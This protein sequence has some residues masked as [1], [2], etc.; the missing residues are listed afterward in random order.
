M[1]QGGR[2]QGQKE[3]GRSTPRGSGPGKQE[4]TEKGSYPADA[5]PMAEQDRPIWELDF[6]LQDFGRAWA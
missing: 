2:L 6:G 5:R 1:P 3:I 4:L